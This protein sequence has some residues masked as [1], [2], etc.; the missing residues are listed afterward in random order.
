[1]SIDKAKEILSKHN[2][3]NRHSTFQLSNF[4]LGKELTLQGK[5]WQCVREI[6]AR[7]ETIDNLNINIED[8]EDNIKLIHIKRKKLSINH[9][10]L[11]TENRQSDEELDLI[12]QEFELK[13]NK[14]K[15]QID[16]LNKTI[17]DLKDRIDNSAEE[18]RFFVE[19]FEHLIKVGDWKEF[20]DIYSQ[21]EY[22]NSKLQYELSMRLALQKP[23]DVELAKTIDAI[24]KSLPV[25]QEFMK[26]F[27]KSK[28]IEE[29][30]AIQ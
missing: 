26:L 17:K 14:Y 24:P 2:I 27:S 19:A 11:L 25:K 10:R 5:Q 18:L 20:D 6:Q 8:T 12:S 15:R 28:L 13:E 21:A 23:V 1:M 29:Q 16:S 9:N 7:I 30:N 4:V 22:W 3:S